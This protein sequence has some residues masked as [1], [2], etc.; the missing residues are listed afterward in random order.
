LTNSHRT[1]DGFTTR[2]NR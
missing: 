1:L 2:R